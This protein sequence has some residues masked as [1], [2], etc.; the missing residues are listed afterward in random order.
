MTLAE[1][2]GPGP[3]LEFGIGVR[4]GG[5]PIG[6]ARGVR[7]Q[8]IE[9]FSVAMAEELRR[10][11]GRHID[12]VIGDFATATVPGSFRLVYI[13][14]NTID[15]PHHPGRTG[16][17]FPQRGASDLEWVGCSWWR[18]TYLTFG[19]SRRGRLA[20]VSRPPRTT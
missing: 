9:V 15:K 11:G 20:S 7:V 16:P 12:V 19:D 17:G 10:Q 1:L 2:A 3:A 8:G 18:T 13:L 14:R 4:R 5:R 6:P